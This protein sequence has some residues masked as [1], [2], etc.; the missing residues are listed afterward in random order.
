MIEHHMANLMDVGLPHVIF[1]DAK[2]C[3]DAT[4][5]LAIC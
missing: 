1:V 5:H 2:L 4:C 3:E